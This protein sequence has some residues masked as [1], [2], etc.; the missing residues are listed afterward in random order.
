MA[1]KK[2][3]DY[4]TDDSLR[5]IFSKCLK[6]VDSHIRTHVS[7]GITIQDVEDIFNKHEIPSKY[8]NRLLALSELKYI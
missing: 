2:Q 5:E 1:K 3:N 7:N 6:E 4:E 8:R